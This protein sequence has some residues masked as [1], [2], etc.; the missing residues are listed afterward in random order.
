MMTVTIGDLTF[1]T[2]DD[3]PPRDDNEQDVSPELV[4]S[5]FASE[6]DIAE[7]DTVEEYCDIDWTYNWDV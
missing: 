2:E 4:E 7:Y 5:D 3:F 6:A 1:Y